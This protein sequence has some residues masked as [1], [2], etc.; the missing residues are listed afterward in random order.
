MPHISGGS[1]ARACSTAKLS[2]G[3]LAGSVPVPSPGAVPCER[4]LVFDRV[5]G[6]LGDPGGLGNPGGFGS[7]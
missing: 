4:M 3:D 6:W 7:G 2:L 5:L 1:W